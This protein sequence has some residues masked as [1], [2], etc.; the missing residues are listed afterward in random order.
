MQ[1]D[2]YTFISCEKEKD[3][4]YW[5]LY[6]QNTVGGGIYLGFDA[7]NEPKW[8]LYDGFPREDALNRVKKIQKG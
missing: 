5:W 3:R 4:D 7:E 8:Q 2:K 1:N 6:Y